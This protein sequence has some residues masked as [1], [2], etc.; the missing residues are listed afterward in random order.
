MRSPFLLILATAGIAAAQPVVAP[1][2]EHPGTPGGDSYGDYNITNWFETGYRWAVVNGNVGEYRS[3][4][5]YGNGIRLLGSGLTVNSKDGRGKYFDEILLTT[6]GLGNDPYQ[7]ASMRIQKNGL[8]RYD[9]LWRLNDYYNPG[10][11]L[12]AGEHLMNTRFTLQD[13]DLTLADGKSP[14]CRHDGGA[15]QPGRFCAPGGLE[16]RG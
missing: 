13:Q 1:T 15:R 6:M 12:S 3:Q 10:L 2:P 16:P 11:I 4:V 9:F 8:Y 7:S 14:Q 5:N